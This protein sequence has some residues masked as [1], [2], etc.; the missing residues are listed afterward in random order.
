MNTLTWCWSRGSSVFKETEAGKVSA[1]EEAGVGVS[2]NAS[3]GIPAQQT[4]GA[5]QAPY[6]LYRKFLLSSQGLHSDE[7]ITTCPF[8]QTPGSLGREEDPQMWQSM[9]SGIN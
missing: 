1:G 6:A 4:W 3:V 9:L 5:Y 2:I 8:S 7:L